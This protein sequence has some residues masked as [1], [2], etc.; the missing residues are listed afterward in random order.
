MRRVLAI[1]ACDGEWLKRV[2]EARREGR[3]VSSTISLARLS[4][5]D[6]EWR[7]VTTPRTVAGLR[8][9]GV[10]WWCTHHLRGFEEFDISD[11]IALQIR[12]TPQTDSPAEDQEGGQGDRVS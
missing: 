7:R 1:V 12:P 11:A 2:D 6:E 3:V 8:F 10:E 9:H 4:N 5:P